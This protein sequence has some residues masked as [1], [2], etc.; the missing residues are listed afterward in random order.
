MLYDWVPKFFNLILTSIY[1]SLEMKFVLFS[2]DQAIR[3]PN[4]HANFAPY[5][6][7]K[8]GNYD[9]LTQFCGKT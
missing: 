7:K 8:K 2:L 4:T 3:T 5:Q 6:L 9:A 1:S